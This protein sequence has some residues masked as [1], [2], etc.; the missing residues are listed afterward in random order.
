MNDSIIKEIKITPDLNITMVIGTWCH[1]C[2]EL[3]PQF[4][5]VFHA[6]NFDKKKLTIIGVSSSKKTL[7]T[8]IKGMNIQKVPTVIFYKNKKEIGRIIE[9]PLFSY[10]EHISD[11][12]NQ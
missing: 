9:Y 12:L 11:I 10:E 5:K 6:L 4:M 8:S 3:V 2:Q 1:D 7:G